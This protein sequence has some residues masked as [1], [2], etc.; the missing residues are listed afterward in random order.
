MAERSPYQPP[1]A[2]APAADPAVA[3]DPGDA[4]AVFR[5]DPGCARRA[6]AGNI[7]LAL[8]VCMA[9]PP[10]GLF[11]LVD[12]IATRVRALQPVLFVTSDRIVGLD[13]GTRRRRFIS[14]ERATVREFVIIWGSVLGFRL[15]DGRYCEVQLKHLRRDGLPEIRAAL[16]AVGLTEGT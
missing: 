7:G 11:L 10:V 13:G 9:F 3:I 2:G 8:F 4:R 14:V 16:L 15:R 6:L 1:A 12:A 5:A